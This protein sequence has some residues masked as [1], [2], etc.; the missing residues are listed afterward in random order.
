MSWGLFGSGGRGDGSKGISC[1]NDVLSKGW[2]NVTALGEGAWTLVCSSSISTGIWDG[3]GSG[4]PLAWW[5][6]VST[7]CI[8]SEFASGV[9]CSRSCK[10]SLAS[11]ASASAGDP[12]RARQRLRGHCCFSYDGTVAR[13][14]VAQSEI[15]NFIL[16]LLTQACCQRSY[17][18]YNRQPSN[19]S[20]HSQ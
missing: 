15:H 6:G 2:C 12:N 3:E 19:P 5:T 4:N 17:C 8:N 9:A 1:N 16:S 10:G 14:H 18:K 7:L 11:G 20:V 13:R